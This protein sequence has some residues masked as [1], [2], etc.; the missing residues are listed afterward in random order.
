MQEAREWVFIAILYDEYIPDAD[1]AMED[2]SLLN[3]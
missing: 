2:P 3:R 1:V